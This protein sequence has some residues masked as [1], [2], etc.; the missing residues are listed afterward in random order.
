MQF[1]ESSGQGCTITS[2]KGGEGEDFLERYV[3]FFFSQPAGCKIFSNLEILFPTSFVMQDSF[4]LNFGSPR[5]FTLFRTPHPLPP[6][7][8]P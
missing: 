3:S 1:I 2:V 8:H 6:M 7:L 5:F 4:Y